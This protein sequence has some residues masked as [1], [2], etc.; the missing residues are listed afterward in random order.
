MLKRLDLRQAITYWVFLYIIRYFIHSL[1]KSPRL[2]FVNENVKM[3]KTYQL[4]F[5]VLLMAY[6]LFDYVLF[7]YTKLK[8]LYVPLYYFISY[9]T[10]YIIS[11]GI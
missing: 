11:E 1:F 6:L 9:A 10:V 7:F 2:G 4:C 8:C 5:I 3:F